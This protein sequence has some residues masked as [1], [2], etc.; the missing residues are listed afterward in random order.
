VSRL[1]TVPICS[2]RP[3]VPGIETLAHKFLPGL[4]DARVI[5]RKKERVQGRGG[6]TLHLSD[7]IQPFTWDLG[8]FLVDSDKVASHPGVRDIVLFGIKARVTSA[9][10][11]PLEF[12]H[13]LIPRCRTNVLEEDD[14]RT[15]VFDPSQHTA[16]RATGLSIRRDILFLVVQV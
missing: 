1:A 12:C 14:G 16:E 15:M 6:R 10:P 11:D 9:V 5:R 8:L 3:P 4:G 7:E 13:D 2:A